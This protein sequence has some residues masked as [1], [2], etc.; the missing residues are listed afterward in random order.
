MKVRVYISSLAPCHLWGQ[1]SVAL[2]DTFILQ[3]SLSSCSL[4]PPFFS[5]MEY[6]IF[7]RALIVLANPLYSANIF[8]F[9]SIHCDCIRS[10][11][12]G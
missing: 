7:S 5:P 11:L 12:P 8:V 4:F 2:V 1:K 9:L 3:S 6:F 10:G